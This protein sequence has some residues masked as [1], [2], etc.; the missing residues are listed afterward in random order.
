MHDTLCRHSDSHKACILR[1]QRPPRPSL[2]LPPARPS[3]GDCFS[4]GI[5]VSGLLPGPPSAHKTR[6]FPSLE[7]NPG[8]GFILREPRGTPPHT[9]MGAV[10]AGAKQ[11][12][13]SMRDS[14]WLRIPDSGTDWGDESG[15]LLRSWG[16]WPPTLPL[17]GVSLQGALWFQCA[18]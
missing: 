3:L 2:C 6:G 10:R 8:V 13:Q 4:R 14:K 7:G 18:Q 17:P 11:L 15:Q 9:Q 12:L 16:L 5:T 1:T